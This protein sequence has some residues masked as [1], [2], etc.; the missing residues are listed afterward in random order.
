VRCRRRLSGRSR[1]GTLEPVLDHIE[2]QHELELLEQVPAKL[3]VEQEQVLAKL[4]VELEQEQAGNISVEQEQP[5]GQVL[6]K[7]AVEQD[8]AS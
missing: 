2:K 1:S 5:A 6:P 4:V 3:V 7:L 8:A